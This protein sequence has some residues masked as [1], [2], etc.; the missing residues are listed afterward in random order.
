MEDPDGTRRFITRGDANDA[1][2]P[3]PVPAREV[4]GI[5]QWG[6]PRLGTLLWSLRGSRGL[7]SLVVAPAALLALSE[8][9]ELRR[10]RQARC[11]TCGPPVDRDTWAESAADHGS[12]RERIASKR[13][14]EATLPGCLPAS[15]AAYDAFCTG[16]L[17]RTLRR[18][19]G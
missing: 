19:S 9:R 10:R 4:R 18:R 2:D 6:V 7:L 17:P 8:A 12:G 3:S 14:S 1:D 16:V 15:F 13:T 11:L 5:V